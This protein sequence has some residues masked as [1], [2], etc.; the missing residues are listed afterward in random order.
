MISGG[1]SRPGSPRTGL[2]GDIPEPGGEVTGKPGGCL[3]GA[4]QARRADAGEDDADCPAVAVAVVAADRASR[5][6]VAEPGEEG[7]DVTPAQRR[8]YLPPVLTAAQGLR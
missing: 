5:F 6:Q 8:R 4:G 7:L 3:P 2:G 1:R